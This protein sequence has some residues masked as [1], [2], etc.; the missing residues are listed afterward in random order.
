MKYLSCSSFLVLALAPN[1]LA[2][3]SNIGLSEYPGPPCTK[4]LLPI[5]PATPS[6]P[7]S[8]AAQAPA[9]MG[10][11]GL[12][13]GTVTES[14]L[15]AAYNAKVQKYNLDVAA[16]NAALRDFNSCM[17]VYV[18]NGNADMMRIKQRLDQAVADANAQKSVKGPP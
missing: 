16:Y 13:S 17:Q 1:A 15:S 18:D 8:K 5:E 2:D 10:G 3:G 11:G 4:P 14:S 12:G 7:Y 9:V 6:N